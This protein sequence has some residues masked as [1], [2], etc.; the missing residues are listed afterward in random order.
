LKINQRLYGVRLTRYE[1]ELLNVSS[2][3]MEQVIGEIYAKN[4]SLLHKS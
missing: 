1:H 2:L 3:V 4:N